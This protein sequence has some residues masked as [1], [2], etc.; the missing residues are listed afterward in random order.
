MTD[1]IGCP[2]LKQGVSK[3]HPDTPLANTILT[4]LS[5][6]DLSQSYFEYLHSWILMLQKLPQASMS[7]KNILEEEWDFTKEICP[8]VRGGEAQAGKR[9]WFVTI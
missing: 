1:E 6:S 4:Y 7:L 3:R 5:P 2:K 9:F 8:H